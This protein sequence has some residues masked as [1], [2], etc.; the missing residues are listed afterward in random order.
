MRL[1]HISQDYLGRKPVFRPR[2]PINRAPAESET[3]RICVAPSV[4]QCYLAIG[5]EKLSD[6][7]LF[8][9]TFHV[10][11]VET[12]THVKADKTVADREQT[13]ERWLLEPHQFEHLVKMPYLKPDYRFQGWHTDRYRETLIKRLIEEEFAWAMDQR[14]LK[15]RDREQAKAQLT[16]IAS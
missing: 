8:R 3:P 12:D 1:Y 5:M 9:S 15:I 14:A 4:S 16:L 11:C 10:Y 13:G 7:I 2:V 6:F